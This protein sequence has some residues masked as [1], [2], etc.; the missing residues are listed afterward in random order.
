MDSLLKTLV[1]FVFYTNLLNYL[2]VL[3]GVWAVLWW[4]IENFR[5]VVEITKSVLTPYFQPHENKSLVE[6]YGKWAGE[7]KSSRW[8]A[9]K[10]NVIRI[11][12]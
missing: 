3:A 2:L 11:C 12:K 10:C 9:F 7:N 8:S 1:N 6:K 5:S 4:S